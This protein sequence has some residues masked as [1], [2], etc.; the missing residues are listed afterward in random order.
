MKAPAPSSLD[1]DDEPQGELSPLK[2]RAAAP[3]PL[4]QRPQAV[5]RASGAARIAT[6]EV[7]AE[8]GP[9]DVLEV[10]PTSSVTLLDV[11]DGEAE[12]TYVEAPCEASS[13]D[14]DYEGEYGEGDAVGEAEVEGE[15]MTRAVPPP[16]RKVPFEAL[17]T[18]L[19]GIPLHVSQ[20]SPTGY[21]GVIRRGKAFALRRS[22]R[23]SINGAT[24][25]TSATDA[26]LAYARWAT[27]L[28]RI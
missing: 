20:Q 25:Y 2:D 18:E 12:V 11:D 10:L 3:K 14:D 19:D 24:T 16:C 17:P 8:T 28:T 7:V 9:G 15:A 6:A 26:A 21:T 1:E 4:T 13:E 22:R 23:Y 27:C 5:Q